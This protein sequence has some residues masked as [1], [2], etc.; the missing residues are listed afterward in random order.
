MGADGSSLEG[1]T[2]PPVADDFVPTRVILVRHGESNVTVNRI[3]GGPR[4][5]SGLSAL[6]VQQAERLRDRLAGTGELSATA[7]YSSGYPRARET[8]E[9]IAPSI[10]VD[11]Q[12]DTGLGEHDPGPE[13]DGVSFRDFVDRYGRPDWDGD[14]HSVVFPGGETTAAFHYRVGAALSPIIAEHAGGT[15]VVVCH[16]GVI[17]VAFRL[18]LGLPQSGAFELHTLNT[19]LTEFVTVKPGKWRLARY[20]DSA[21]LAGLPAET[22]RVDA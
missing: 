15:I 18:L 13:C 6:G 4:T 10:G 22:P 14:I 9:I 11:L 21:H 5:C 2:V 1:D 12:I 17:D 8:A 16:G 7:F 20:N 3:I 19:S